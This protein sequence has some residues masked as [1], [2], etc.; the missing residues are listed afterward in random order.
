MLWTD[1]YKPKRLEDIVGQEQGISKIRIFM[2]EWQRGKPRYKALLIYGPPGVG[3]T[4]SIYALANETNAELI[5][6]NAS[7]FRNAHKVKEVLGH[8]SVQMSLFGKNKII[9]VDEVDGIHGKE[10]KG[11]LAAVIKVIYESKFPVFLT[12][13]NP[14]AQNLKPLRN[15]CQFVEFRKVNARAIVSLLERICRREGITYDRKALSAIAQRNNGDVRACIL[16]L[17][18]IAEHSRRVTLEDV[19]DLANRNR[20]QSIFDTLK[21]IFKTKSVMAAILAVANAD[22][23]P[24]ELMLWIEENIA[25]EYEKMDEVAKAYNAISR[26]DVFYGRVR[27]QFW[28]LKA[29][30]NE[31][32]SA[33][34]ALA[35]HEMYRKFTKYRPPALLKKMAQTKEEREVLRK[36][37]EKFAK[38]LHASKNEVRR[39]Y[40]PLIKMIF[41]KNLEKAV[42]ISRYLRLSKEEVEILCENKEIAERIYARAKA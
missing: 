10:D 34:V 39:E 26:A 29:Y 37:L 41:A 23:D 12:A 42:E 9:L 14:W 36:V 19:K 32:M 20:E 11:G 2:N 7:D 16:D 13:N 35:K 18:A 4:A 3:K 33:G 6:M 31:L 27:N 25:N 40:L 8:A 5:E 21:I 15:I 38:N 28:R 17:Q 22:R 1:K 24:D 30:G